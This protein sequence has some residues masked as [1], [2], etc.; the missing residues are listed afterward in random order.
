MISTDKFG[1][2]SPRLG[3]ATFPNIPEARECGYVGNIRGWVYGNVYIPN[4]E[5]GG[6][7]LRCN[8]QNKSNK[9]W[10]IR[11]VIAQTSK[12]KDRKYSHQYTTQSS[13]ITT[14]DGQH[15]Q[16]MWEYLGICGNIYVN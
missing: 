4:R 9:M 12:Q 1:M 8:I 2:T 3:G 6:V 13:K 11:T 10:F 16:G 7:Y 14:K 15:S 5:Y